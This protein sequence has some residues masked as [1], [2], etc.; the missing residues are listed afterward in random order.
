MTSISQSS[1]ACLSCRLRQSIFS[2]SRR[3]FSQ[4]N[5]LKNEAR[6]SIA[7]DPVPPLK[8]MRQNVELYSKNCVD[9]RYSELKDHPAR[10]LALHNKALKLH[11][12]NRPSWE[13]I[14]PLEAQLAKLSKK[15][16][17]VNEEEVKELAALRGEAQAIKQNLSKVVKRTTKISDEIL[18]LALQLPNLTSPETPVGDEPKVLGYINPHPDS[19]DPNRKFRSH[20]EIGTKLNLLDFSSSA[21]TTGWG[22]YYLLNDAALLEQA[23]IQYAL[24]LATKQGWKPVSP[25]SIVYTHMADACGFNPRDHHGEQQ[26]YKLAQ[27]GEKKPGRS[28]AGTAEIPLAAMKAQK[29]FEADELPLKV[30][31]S[32]RCY[33]AEAGARGVDTKGLYRVHEFTKVEMFAWTNPYSQPESQDPTPTPTPPSSDPT[34]P[35]PFSSDNP[36]FTSLLTLQKTLLRTLGLHARVLEMPTSDLG[37]S[38]YRKIDMEVYFP[39]RRDRQNKKDGGAW[40]EVSSASMCTDY[41]TRRLGTRVRGMGGKGTGGSFVHTINGTAVAVPRVLAA[42]L[43]YGWVEE[44][45]VVRVPEVLRKWMGGREVIGRGE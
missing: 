15:E 25:P 32:S 43:E 38:A 21:N 8:H 27:K 20:V 23:L 2:Q 13:K 41:Q 4:S 30:I 14:K 7:P 31:G 12:E 39:S 11:Q 5:R 3:A 1:Y 36:T 6:P 17:L 22:W 37:A 35:T 42:V 19:I 34:S 33:R 16:N 9:R 10:I 44:E 29:T 45:G 24:E 26:I 40:G 18:D 28:L